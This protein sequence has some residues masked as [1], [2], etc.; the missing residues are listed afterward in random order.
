MTSGWRAS[1]RSCGCWAA[2]CRKAGE[3]SGGEG[4]GGLPQ[5]DRLDEQH[6]QPEGGDGVAADRAA[7]RPAP[8]VAC[9]ATPKPRHAGAPSRDE[10][11][12]LVHATPALR[13]HFMRMQ[14]NWET[15][16]AHAIA[17]E[18]GLPG[19]ELQARALACFAL[20]IG[21]LA[22]ESPDPAHALRT[23]FARL[24]N[25]WTDFPHPGP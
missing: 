13:D 3:A 22:Q 21:A 24:R 16:L 7:G 18:S 9:L 8:G 10:F 2:A 1:A 20:D 17:E 19:D 4:R 6:G 12:D 11:L 15:T 23:L 5:G 14:R 25:G